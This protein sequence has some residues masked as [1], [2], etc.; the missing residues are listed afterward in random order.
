MTPKLTRKQVILAALA[1]IV[2]IILAYHIVRYEGEQ[3]SL[4][5]AGTVV[6][7]GLI[8]LIVIGYGFTWTGFGHSRITKEDS[9][10]VR[11]ARTLWD[12]MQLLIV[13]AVLAGVGLWFS[14]VQS[15]AQRE[16]GKN[17]VE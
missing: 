6:V 12:W 10:E 16:Y 8:L 3:A 11:Q 14:G 13:S 1:L 9:E 17:I 2:L 4:Q 15:E 7:I 5:L